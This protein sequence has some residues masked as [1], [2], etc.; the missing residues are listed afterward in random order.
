M[1][2]GV[3]RSLSPDQALSVAAVIGDGLDAAH[4]GAP[5]FG[6]QQIGQG[7]DFCRTLNQARL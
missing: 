5:G 4:G 2:S 1:K 3:C 6:P 7:H